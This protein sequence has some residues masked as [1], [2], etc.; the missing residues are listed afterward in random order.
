MIHPVKTPHA[1]QAIGHYEQGLRLGNL[2]FTSGQLP[3]DPTTGSLIG[4]DASELA[5]RVLQNVEAV[6]K[7][8]GGRKESVLRMN[9]YLTDAS[10]GPKV[11]AVFAE[12]F[13][14]HRPT[15]TTVVVKQLPLGAA[16][17]M[18]AIAAAPDSVR[19]LPLDS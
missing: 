14:A 6:L 13:G 8:A 1:P 15:R 12:F 10:Q 17:E 9:V 11:N 4:G 7:A 18:D 16:L 3:V 19:T 5:L 2:I